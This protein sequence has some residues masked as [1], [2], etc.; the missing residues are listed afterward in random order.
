[1]IAY[2]KR[3]PHEQERQWCTRTCAYSDAIAIDSIIPLYYLSSSLVPWLLR[4]WK[5]VSTVCACA[6]ISPVIF[7]VSANGI[8]QLLNLALQ[9]RMT[10]PAQMLSRH[11]HVLECQVRDCYT[12]Y[13]IRCYR[14]YQKIRACARTVGSST[15]YRHFACVKNV[16]AEGM[17]MTGYTLM[18]ITINN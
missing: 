17:N 8:R 10:Y 11:L 4:G 9:G 18:Y 5:M 12:T 1:M 13:S 15:I 3:I 7:A 2:H 16:C 14:D 6:I